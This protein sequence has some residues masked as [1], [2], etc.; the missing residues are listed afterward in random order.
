MGSNN[1]SKA[2]TREQWGGRSGKPS[3]VDKLVFT[4]AHKHQV[5]GQADRSGLPS[6]PPPHPFMG[7]VNSW[8]GREGGGGCWQGRGTGALR[9]PRVRHTRLGSIPVSGARL[10]PGTTAHRTV[11][12]GS[13]PRRQHIAVRI[14]AQDI[15]TE[16]IT[17]QRWPTGIGAADHLA[18]CHGS[19]PRR[20]PIADLILGPGAELLGK[21]VWG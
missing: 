11:C 21:Q 15:H 16:D 2:C 6:Y 12:H 8:V 18:V 14:L 5:L 20:Q 10:A 19:R 17:D 7:S 9:G 4:K 1:F 3:L 13:R